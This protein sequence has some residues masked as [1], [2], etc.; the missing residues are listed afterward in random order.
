VRQNGKECP[1]RIAALNSQLPH[2]VSRRTQ[3]LPGAIPKS[4]EYSPLILKECSRR[5]WRDEIDQ[6]ERKC[7]RRKQKQTRV[8]RKLDAMARPDLHKHSQLLSRS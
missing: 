5:E 2:S 1:A 8:F 6:V 3:Q 4:P 7:G